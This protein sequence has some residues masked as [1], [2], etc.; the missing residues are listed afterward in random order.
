[1]VVNA[2]A[3]SDL[4]EITVRYMFNEYFVFPWP[5][6]KMH[7]SMSNCLGL[8]NSHFDLKSTLSHSAVSHNWQTCLFMCV[9][10][11][12]NKGRTISCEFY[13]SKK[14]LWIHNTKALYRVTKNSLNLNRA[15][16]GPPN[17]K[18]FYHKRETNKNNWPMLE[19]MLCYLN[20][21]HYFLTY[22]KKC[23]NL[24]TI[25]IYFTHQSNFNIKSKH[26]FLFTFNVCPS[27]LFKTQF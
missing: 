15:K 17:I 13:Y 20:Q 10:C 4:A 1:M 27:R 3:H 8:K 21:N 18:T 9:F 5:I 14:I 11:H 23:A 19:D 16:H 25:W 24:K 2:N 22:I 6:S 7:S 26:R 12:N